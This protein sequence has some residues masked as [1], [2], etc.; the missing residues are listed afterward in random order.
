L[1]IA[2][3]FRLKRVR[4]TKPGALVGGENVSKYFKRKK[5]YKKKENKAKEKLHSG[6]FLKLVNYGQ[7]KLPLPLGRYL[8]ANFFMIVV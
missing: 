8:I 5:K 2:F 6:I 3:S 1:L 4:R 7:T